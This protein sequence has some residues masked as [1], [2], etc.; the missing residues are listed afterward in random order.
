MNLRDPSNGFSMKM[1]WKNHFFSFSEPRQT[2][3]K[4]KFCIESLFLRFSVRNIALENMR[5]AMS[6]EGKMPMSDLA[7]YLPKFNLIRALI[8]VHCT[9]YTKNSDT[10]VFDKYSSTRYIHDLKVVCTI[11]HENILSCIDQ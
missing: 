11:I 9:R 5:C 3:R 1:D 2:N 8:S 4:R 6:G 7:L 10:R